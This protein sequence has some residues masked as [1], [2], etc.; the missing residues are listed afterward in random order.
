M[1]TRQRILDTALESFGTTGVDGTSLDA[2]ARTLGL[3]KQSIL[4]YFQSKNGLFQAVVDQAATEFIAELDDVVGADDVWDQVEGTVRVVFRLALQRP[5]LLGLLREASR[6]GSMVA[7]QL[8]SRLSNHIEAAQ[9]SLEL[10]L[11]EGRVAGDNARLLLFSLYST[12]MGVA[13]EV[14]VLRAMGIEPSLR[15][16]A[17]RRSELLRFLYAA[18][19]PQPACL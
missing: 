11:K 16:L 5:A 10:A 6:P 4:Y 1:N 14:E 13:T 19:S 7:V 17:E 3:R 15:S 9:H 8:T 12:I 18:L 2:L